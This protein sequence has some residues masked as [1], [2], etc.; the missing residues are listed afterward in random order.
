M[1]EARAFWVAAPG[2][3]EIKTERLRALTSGE[4]LVH[5]RASA[6]SRGTETLVFRGEVPQSEWQ[7]M[8]CPF[9]E[10]GFPAPVKYGYAV[11]GVVEDGPIEF[12]GRRVF[13]LH[14]HQDRFIVPEEAVVGIPD[15][16]PDRRAT[17][18]ANM[19]TAIN[20]LWD[21][22]P[23]L[24]DRI[25]VVGAGVV[26][27]LVG[28]LAARLPG[29]EVELIDIDP[30][31]AASAATRAPTTPAPTTAI[32]SPGPGTPSQRPFI[33][34]SMLAASVARRSG[35]SSGTTT[36]ASS[37]TMNRS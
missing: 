2:R 36:T 1:V 37:G 3:G 32:R 30:S 20:G 29:A 35:T 4:L 24:G 15:D 10:G 27:T 14:P 16:V 7:Q 19:E 5:A 8:R 21:G 12:W 25:A 31:R 6:I 9:Q 23:G 18:A 28:A 11:A 22:V 13:C 34:V 26:G 33:A 17:L